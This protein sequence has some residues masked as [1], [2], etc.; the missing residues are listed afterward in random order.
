MYK[1]YQKGYVMQTI[2]REFTK[3]VNLMENLASQ[4][5]FGNSQW[6]GGPGVVSCK[7]IKAQQ[8]TIFITVYPWKYI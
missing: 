6:E 5:I 1:F 3:S 7:S 4:N 2:K 8:F